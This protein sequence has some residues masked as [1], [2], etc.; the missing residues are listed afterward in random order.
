M[1]VVGSRI[2]PTHPKDWPIA[3]QLFFLKPM[4]DET[5]K[6]APLLQTH[7]WLITKWL[8][9]FRWIFHHFLHANNN[10]PLLLCLIFCCSVSVRL[11]SVPLLC[12][13]LQGIS[14]QKRPGWRLQGSR[15]MTFMKHVGLK[16]T[17]NAASS[18]W[19]ELNTLFNTFL[20]QMI[21]NSKA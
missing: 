5:G 17:Q 7:N 21:N 16:D 8:T 20:M 4:G 18:V 13:K 11:K 9:A 19:T 6:Y 2:R 14:F 15:N 1:F 12:N 3:D 10:F